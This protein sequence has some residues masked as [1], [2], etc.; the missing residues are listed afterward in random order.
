MQLITA[1]LF[2]LCGV[3]WLWQFI[4]EGS[5]IKLVI[6]LIWVSGGVIHTVRYIKSRKTPKEE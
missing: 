2:Y 3:I 4:G 6:G 5:F 1:I